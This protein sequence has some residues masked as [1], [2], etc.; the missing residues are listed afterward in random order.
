MTAQTRTDASVRDPLAGT[1]F[2]DARAQTLEDLTGVVGRARACAALG[3][4]R[5][6][7]YRHHRTSWQPV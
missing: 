5:A 4:S 7:Y 3:V 6:T 2:E 1:V